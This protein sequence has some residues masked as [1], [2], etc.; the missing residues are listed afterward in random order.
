MFKEKTGFV[1]NCCKLIMR[2]IQASP[3]TLYLNTKFFYKIT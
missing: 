3:I 2:V 1:D